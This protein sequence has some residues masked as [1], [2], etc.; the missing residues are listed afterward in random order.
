MLTDLSIRK[1]KADDRP[2]KVA[3]R[4]GLYAFVTRAG[5][6]SFRFDYTECRGGA[7][8]SSW[9]AMTSLEGAKL[10]ARSTLAICI[11]D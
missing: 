10:H 3:E 7:K 11:A 9:A 2:Y 8:R 5:A 6:V 1:L 4:D